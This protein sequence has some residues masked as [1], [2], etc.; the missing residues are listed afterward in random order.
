LAVSKPTSESTN[1]DGI[2]AKIWYS[3]ERIDLDKANSTTFD[4]NDGWVTAGEITDW[5]TVKAVAVS[6]IGQEIPPFTTLRLEISLWDKDIYEHVDQS[7]YVSSAIFSQGLDEGDTG[8]KTLT[9]APGEKDRS[10]MLTVSGTPTRQKADITFIDDTTGY[11]LKTRELKGYSGQHSGY[12][13]QTD[14]DSYKD[15]YDLVSDSTGGQEIVFDHDEKTDQHYEVHLKQKQSTDV[16][17]TKIV[18]RTIHYVYSDGTKASEDV[19]QTV[20]FTR[21]VKKNPATGEVTYGD[22]TS[23]NPT[24][25]AVLSPTIAGYTPDRSTVGAATVSADSNDLEETVTY[26]KNG[27]TPGTP[28]TPDKPDPKPGEP[29]DKPDDKPGDTPK[30]DKPNIDIH[31]DTPSKPH[32]NEAKHDKQEKKQQ[33]KQQVTRRAQ[34]KT[35]TG[36]VTTETATELPQTGSNN[37]KRSA[38]ATILIGLAGLLSLF[39]FKKKR[40]NN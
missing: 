18:K 32:I 2:S 33:Q 28:E 9:I 15:S 29:E 12:T 39:G 14:L 36:H 16:T 25:D 8:L 13:T 3:T 17:D 40:K 31:Q 1:D 23:D 35:V 21:H 26:T 34:A 10:A 4:P 38:L 5:S 6:L 37:E 19:V 30:D 11:T 24:F 20:T 7:I 27:N 22:W